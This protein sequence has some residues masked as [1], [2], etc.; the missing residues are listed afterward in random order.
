VLSKARYR[1]S[2]LLLAAVLLFVLPPSHL[3]GEA[4]KRG[5]P[6]VATTGN[7]A[8]TL[9]FSGFVVDQAHL[10]TR[11]EIGRLTSRLDRFQQRTSHQFAVVTVSDLGGQ[12]VSSFTL[13]LANRWGVGRAGF[14]DGIVLLVAPRER[15]ARIEIGGGLER[16]LT[17]R[18]CAQIMADAIIPQF[19]RGRMAS[20]ID[21][22]VT[23][24]IA[25]IDGSPIAI[26][27][28]P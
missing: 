15:Q 23:A 18:V 5:V 1:R 14:N 20:G 12:D 28:P 22:G 16:I 7:L 3:R 17:D 10:L 13:T 21:A 27:T 19:R 11:E 4:T 8:R 25:R 2:T 24:I 26:G 9:E 6:A